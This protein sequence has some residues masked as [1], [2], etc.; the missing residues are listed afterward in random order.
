MV[1]GVLGGFDFRTF[2]QYDGSMTNPPCTE[3]VKWVVAPIPRA[4]SQA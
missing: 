4:I 1:K 2:Y 3:G